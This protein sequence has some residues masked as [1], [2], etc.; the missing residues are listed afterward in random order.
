MKKRSTGFTLVE[1]L[2]VLGIIALLAALLFPAFS[3]AREGARQ[4]SCQSNLQQISLAV[5]Q[6][7][8]EEGRYPDS[9]LD[10]L[11]E[12]A[13]FVEA[14]GTTS[15]S[16][17]A[18]APGYFKGGMDSL[19]CPDDDTDSEIPRSSYGSLTKA[20]ITNFPATTDTA[21]RDSFTGDY[22]RYVW[23]YWGMRQDGFAYASAEEAAKASWDGG[24]SHASPGTPPATAILLV[25]PQ[26]PFNSPSYPAGYDANFPINVIKYSMSNRYAPKSTIVTHCVYHRVPTANNLSSPSMLY[27]APTVDGSNSREIVTRLNQESK[28]VDATTWFDQQTWQK[29]TP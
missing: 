17:S 2:V 10:L 27:V 23:N 16:L 11:G 14:D 1:I 25:D 12:G 28:N 6:Y 26:V 19:V 13:R 20:P 4:S 8:K 24:T 15:N 3:R 9:L 21:G 18:Q 5:D 22:G 7:R 29:Q